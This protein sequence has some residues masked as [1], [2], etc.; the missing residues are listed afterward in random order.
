MNAISRLSF[1]IGRVQAIRKGV[2]LAAT[3]L[4]IAAFVLVE[5]RWPGGRDI[6][7][8]LEWLGIALIIICIVGRTWCT[9]YIGGRKNAA[10]VDEGPYSVTR[11]PLYMFSLAGAAGVGAQLG[12]FVLALLVPAI[13]WLVFRVV[14]AREEKHLFAALGEPYSDYV[15]RV[16][17][18]LPRWSAWRNV[19]SLEVRPALVV[20]TF[21]DACFF[22]LAI[23]A[24]ELF[25]WLQASGVIP[26]LLRIP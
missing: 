17:R 20:H 16:P 9:L 6:H 8:G 25:E 15:A 19:D 14:V 21:V 23:P 12:S 22:L 26:I 10:V 7:E 11:N 3:G 18:F 1:D 13:V 24:A 5:S 4:L 2:L